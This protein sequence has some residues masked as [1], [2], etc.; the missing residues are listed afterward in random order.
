MTSGNITFNQTAAQI[1][2]DAMMILNIVGAGDVIN[3]N[4]LNFGMNILNKMT[5]AWMGQGIHLWTEKAGT[6]FLV[7]GQAKYLL[8]AGANGAKASDGSGTPVETTLSVAAGSGANSIT[9]TTTTGMSV[10]DVIGVCQTNQVILWTTIQSIN[11]NTVTLNTTLTSAAALGN[12]VFTYTTQL[13][14][15]LS[16][17]SARLRNNSGFDR[18][19]D[20]KAREDY[21]NIPQ[22]NITGSP[23]ILFCSPQLGADEVYIWPAPSDVNQRIEITYLYPIQDFTSSTDLP[24]FP[25]EWLEALTFN[26]AV[27]LAPAYGISLSSGGIQGNP[28]LLLQA[29]NYLEQ[30]KAWDSEQ[31]SISIV[32]RTQYY[33]K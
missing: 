7:Q 27:R 24:D 16:V 2:T 31:P 21:M 29:A 18:K 11:S 13:P 32:P 25:Q 33:P 17:Q 22:K 28:D 15:I 9:V 26:L 3:N 4:D 20:I 10:N 5:K 14:R 30:M 8:Q 6:I 19:M 12:G 1:I 23:I